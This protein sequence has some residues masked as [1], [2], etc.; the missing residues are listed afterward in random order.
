MDGQLMKKRP[1]IFCEHL[2]KKPQIPNSEC[3]RTQKWKF[4]RYP[5]H[6][7]FTELYYLENDS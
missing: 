4:I 6:L 7:E 2:M 3:I 5:K 1:S